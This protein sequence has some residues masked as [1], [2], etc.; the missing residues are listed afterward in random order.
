MN[1]EGAR[2]RASRH[3]GCG[4]SCFIA[5]LAFVLLL[6]MGLYFFIR[7][8]DKHFYNNPKVGV[9]KEISILNR[10]LI[11][12]ASKF[13]RGNISVMYQLEISDDPYMVTPVRISNACL[14][15]NPLM[16]RK[17]KVIGSYLPENT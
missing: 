14:I 2:P 16:H 1:V 6:A 3:N 15:Y 4:I 10:D 11:V 17:L 5:S 9:L 8:I 13:F 7:S 12:N